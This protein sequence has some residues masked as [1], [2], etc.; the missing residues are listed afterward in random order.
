MSYTALY[1]KWRPDTFEEVKG[2]EP[3]VQTLRNQI[4]HSRVG[5]AY[6]FCG[7]RGTGKTTMAK[8]MAKAVNCE[9]LKDGSPCGECE[10]CKAISAGNSMNV[11]EID[12]AS[13]NGVDN[14]RQ[15]NNAVTYMPTT[16]KY[17]VYIID[18][19]HMLSSG[20][21]N[22]LLKTLE[23]PPEYVIFILATTE[24]YRIPVTIMSRCQRYDF[25]RI[26]LETIT[27]RLVEILLR[28]GAEA[29]REA[30]SYVARAADGSMRD[31][32][33]ILDRCIS[34]NLGARLELDNVLQAIGAVGNELYIRLLKAV[35]SYRVRDAIETVSECVW[36]GKELSQLASEFTVFLRNV[37]ML[38]L[39]PGMDTDFPK[40]VCEKIMKEFADLSEDRLLAYINVLNEAAAK[41]SG[42]TEKKILFE[43]AVIKL[44][45]PEMR[46]DETALLE[47]VEQLEKKLEEGVT[48]QMAAYPE[49]R[50]E[51]V[52]GP[53]PSGAPAGD[54]S[55]SEDGVSGEEVME[56]LKEKYSP[57]DLD[58]IMKLT[59]SFAQI[60]G[61][62]SPFIKNYVNKA[63][64]T[65]G[66]ET[67][68]LALVLE[69]NS[70]NKLAIEFL[71][72]TDDS[73]NKINLDAIAQVI[74]KHIGKEVKVSL[75]TTGVSG[76]EIKIAEKFDLSKIKF[77]N[78]KRVEN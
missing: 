39:A 29:S 70:A 73:G 56:N 14:I 12:A 59:D 2:Q 23:E 51:A 78:I 13:N 50:A 28:E 72:T 36:Q 68:E 3:I 38:K 4:K 65:P 21:F 46:M 77:D 44:C 67:N 76:G 9:N 25:R 7:T 37:L 43:V 30:V 45:T 8:L 18:E 31:A 6:L 41:M 48:V 19:V 24:S 58:D 69:N 42:V 35:A 55:D 15:I 11:V 40:E 10:S 34:Y 20:A 54:G 61:L 1:R 33:S 71:S 74:S 17:L 22:A 64:P 52:A 49:A 32:L 63:I 26:S 5:H 60:R 57:A 75:R 66:D 27:D 16:G 62:L 53:V 47:R